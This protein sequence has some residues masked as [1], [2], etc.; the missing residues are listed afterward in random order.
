MRRP[1]LATVA[2]CDRLQSRQSRIPY[3]AVALANDFIHALIQPSAASSPGSPACWGLA[4]KKRS[5]SEA[6]H[7]NAFR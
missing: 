6:A 2:F 5:E 7:E 1:V 3:G 4:A